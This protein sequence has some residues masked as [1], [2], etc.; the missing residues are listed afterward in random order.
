MSFYSNTI[1]ADSPLVYYRF[2]E[3]SGTTVTDSSGNAN[4][5]TY[6]ASGFTYNQPSSLRSDTDPS[7]KFTGTGYVTLPASVDISTFTAFTLEIRFKYN[8]SA[9]RLVANSHT[10]SDHKGM[11]L[12]INAA[13]AGGLFDVGNGTTEYNIYFGTDVST[14][15]HHIICVWNGSSIKLYIDGNAIG[16]AATTGT[17]A[18]SGFNLTLGRTPSNNADYI[19]CYADEFALYKNVAFSAAQVTTHTQAALTATVTQ[20]NTVKYVSKTSVAS[21]LKASFSSR[22]QIF[23]KSPAKF[24]S[25]ASAR[26]RA[27]ASF[28]SRA[29]ITIKSPAKYTSRTLLTSRQ[30]AKFATR[31]A[32]QQ[33][34][35]ATSRIKLVLSLQL[36]ALFKVLST[37]ELFLK[38]ITANKNNISF[39]KADMTTPY[40]T[41]H[42]VATLT[43]DTNTPIASVASISVLVVYP[44]ASTTSLSLGSG[45]ENLGN[46]Q[47]KAIYS[48]KGSGLITELWMVTSSDGSVVEAKNKIPVSF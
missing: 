11:Q 35:K 13:G 5:G 48:T 28:V 39:Q 20:P 41:I 18:A 30:T 15:W 47:Y 2:S 42:T 43:D 45:V 16:N 23:L 26:A 4:H 33:R 36:K 38:F 29:K 44:D 37:H 32:I 27:A 40:S 9:G 3:T 8:G 25:K 1:L 6:T 21:K 46:G 24:L 10:D 17:I 7:I 19:Q 14:G 22:S 12:A 34:L 31:A